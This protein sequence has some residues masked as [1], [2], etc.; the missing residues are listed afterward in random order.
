MM[1]DVLNGVVM[2]LEDCAFP[3]VHG[4]YT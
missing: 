2:E 3:L 1:A 4:S